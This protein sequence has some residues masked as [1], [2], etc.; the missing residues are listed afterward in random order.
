MTTPI[1]RRAI[2]VTAAALAVAT[3]GAGIAGADDVQVTVEGTQNPAA[4][5]GQY[6]VVMRPGAQA[7]ANRVDAVAEARRNGAQVQQEYG[8][9]LQGFAARLPQRALDLLRSN[10]SVA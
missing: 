8:S 5:E 7:A 2:A 6:I 4:I 10:S 1:W 9:A 3:G